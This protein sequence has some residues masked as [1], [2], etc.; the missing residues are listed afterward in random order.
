MLHKTSL[1]HPNNPQDNVWFRDRKIEIPYDDGL[2]FASFF[3]VRETCIYCTGV[4]VCE[5]VR[6]ETARER[7]IHK[8]PARWLPR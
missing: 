2:C 3:L 8:F 6:G 4:C 7:E 1:H 5:A